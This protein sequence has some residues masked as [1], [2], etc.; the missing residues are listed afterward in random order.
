MNQRTDSGKKNLSGVALWPRNNKA[1]WLLSH[2]ASP[3]RDADPSETPLARA[4]VRY[5]SNKRDNATLPR[6][7]AGASFPSPGAV[8]AASLARRR[9]NKRSPVAVAK[10]TSALSLRWIS[11]WPPSAPAWWSS[12]PWARC[13]SACRRGPRPAR[14]RSGRTPG[15]AARA[16][17]SS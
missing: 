7:P 11:F 8:M 13:W 10:P 15:I 5:L 9:V 14:D 17:P 1:C 3:Q 2:T 16:A 12:Q 6:K 4:F